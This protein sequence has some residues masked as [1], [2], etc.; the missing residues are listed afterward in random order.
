VTDPR[1]LRVGIIGAGHIAT[2]HVQGYRAAG[3]QVVAVADIDPQVVA[4]R[5]KEW[6]VDH[7]FTDFLELVRMPDLDAVSVCTPNTFHGA[8]ALAAA[9]A[10]KHVLC[11][12]PI[13]LSLPEADEMIDACRD[14]GVVLQ[15]NH[16][17]RSNR[18]VQRARQMLD[19]GE[20]G[21][22]TFVRLRQAHDWAGA[23]AVRPSFRHRDLA[24]GG[25][26]LDN[27]CHLFDLA[28]YLGGPV[29][30]IF[31][32]IATLKFQTELEDT[33]TAS[34]LFE[35]G[36][37]GEVETAWTATGWE[38]GFWVYGTKGAL[39][40]TSRPG[41]PILRHVHRSSPET[42]WAEPDATSWEL[43]GG[44]SDHTRHIRAFIAAIRGERDVICTGE[45]GREA[46]R[47]VHAGYQS[48]AEGR[49]V[50]L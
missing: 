3:A 30:E 25:T 21:R 29:A 35:S 2:F 49:P 18:A 14:A 22:V 15:V 45:D 38:E 6:A 16:H 12:K 5:A 17:L 36:A 20:L 28:R 46:V 4:A 27:G 10:G 7:S 34:L 32:R 19:A 39:E 37:L 13:S 42:T 24:G 40:Y 50:R 44:G 9:A 8:A 41:R 48:A 31:A 47:L 43:A 11:E 33:A 26:L 23:A 1:P